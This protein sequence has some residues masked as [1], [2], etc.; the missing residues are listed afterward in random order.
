MQVILTKSKNIPGTDLQVGASLGK[1]S[2]SFEEDFSSDLNFIS[3][4]SVV[5]EKKTF[6]Q[7]NPT[8]DKG[9]TPGVL[10][11]QLRTEIITDSSGDKTKLLVTGT[12]L[13]ISSYDLNTGWLPTS[14]SWNDVDLDL[15]IVVIGQ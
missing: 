4:A 1:G 14:G 11:V 10:S 7:Q 15:K 12:V 2:F 3:S 8:D 6:H 13:M 9:L 5:A